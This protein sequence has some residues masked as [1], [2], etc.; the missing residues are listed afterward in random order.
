[1]D[2]VNWDLLTPQQQD[3]IMNGA[4]G[5]IPNGIESHLGRPPTKNTMTLVVLAVSLFVVTLCVLIRAYAK[6]I[7]LKRV[8]IEDGKA[9]FTNQDSKVPY[10][11]RMKQGVDS[12][13]SYGLFNP[14]IS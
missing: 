12:S 7:I 10:A 14:D 1:M 5:M 2:I 4:A 11:N 6:I 8:R 3:E 13:L 9:G